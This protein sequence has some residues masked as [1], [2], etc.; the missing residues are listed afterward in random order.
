MNKKTF[1]MELAGKILS[2]EFNDLAENAHGSVIMKYENTAV[3]VTCVMSKNP[4]VGGDFFPL[5]VDFEERFYASGQI[6][7]S[8]FI[9]REGKPSD[10]AILSGRIIDRT[11]RPLFDGRMRHEVQVVATTLAVD[12][13]A[14]DIIAVNAASLALCVSPIPWNG[15]IGSVRIA[16][17]N[18][19]WILM[20]PT[21]TSE[22]KD[23]EYEAILT[24][25]GK[26]GNINM[27]E[28]EGN[29]L[30]EDLIMEALEI[31]AKEISKI[32]DFQKKI[33]SEIGKQKREIE[34]MEVSE[35]IISLFNEKILP[36]FEQT[37]FANIAGRKLE[38]ELMEEWMKIVEEHEEMDKS[39]AA[40]Y[41]DEEVN[42][43]LHRKAIDE[44][45]RPDGRDF[46][47]VRPIFAEAGGISPVHHG[48]GIFYRGGTHI[49]SVLTLG[50]PNDAQ[51]IEGMEVTEKKK[52]MHH[53]NFPPYSSGEVG[54]VG[55]TNR[56]AIGHGALAEKALL[57]VLPSQEE[58]PYTIRIVSEALA[59]NGST[60]M[61]SVCGSTLALMDAGVPIK[62]Q[63]AGIASGLMMDDSNKYKVLT[64]IQG[65]EDHHGDMDF[66]V[67]GT[68][69]GVT[70]IQMDVKVDGIPLHILREAFEKAKKARMHI[71]SIMESAIS[72]PRKEIN[73]RAPK[74]MVLKIKPDQI[75]A[76]IGGGGKV[77]KEI[78]E[79]TGAEIDI[80][81]DGTVYITGKNGSAEAAFDWISDLT[82][83]WKRGMEAM[84]EVVRI[85]EFG[86]F[87]K[88]SRAIDGM[89]HVSEIAPWRVN[90]PGDLLTI[91]EIVPV[92]VLEADEEKGRVSLSIKQ[93]DPHRYDD[94]KPK[95]TPRPERKIEHK[96]T[97]S[98]NKPE[99]KE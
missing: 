42:K 89:V 20:P 52:Y 40:Y 82:K 60:S 11:I 43:L 49:M 48:T 84:G 2:A 70:A 96:D 9:R 50:G 30:S 98:E 87:V 1:E 28:M 15:P 10:N 81:D 35:D 62:K 27:I 54:R 47:S 57:P 14:A 72:T 67:A 17:K 93:R 61:G 69:D 92:V 78:R 79:K 5:T 64:D 95:E 23:L 41:F 53:Y 44:N 55:S 22:N 37:I 86:A 21:K 58:F 36:K 74:I 94:K 99:V 75:G 77:V 25:C 71:L 29:E 59:S 33:I 46:D 56:R 65:P 7:G 4:K 26:D 3:L 85:T 19:S 97:T 90:K 39:L 38:Y 73:S 31:A 13:Y 80:E 34:L 76:V 88:L 32:E 66:K 68:K 63:V 16:R 18:N 12:S 45:V 83:E 24:L 91:G 8:Q 6:L 51:T